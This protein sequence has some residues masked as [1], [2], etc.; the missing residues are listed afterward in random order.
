MSVLT[1]PLPPQAALTSI[2]VWRMSVDTYHAMIDVARLTS[3]DPVE[4]VEGVLV[5][6]M[7]KKAAH[8]I[9]NDRLDESIRPLLPA[10][11][12]RQ[13]QEPITLSD[14]EPEPDLTI[15][16]GRSSDYPDGHPGPPDVAL[17]VEVSDTTLRLDRDAKFRA[18]ARA[19]I[20]V[21][22]IVDLVGRTIDVHSTP[23]PAA[24]EPGY[25]HTVSYV[26]GQRVPVT[27]AGQ[28]VGEV[29]VEDILP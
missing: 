5:Y 3:D 17:V 24:V 19:G 21:Y 4:L 2:P 12:S 22:W 16:R 10:G 25:R 23:E 20:A 15:Y 28:T 27:V 13:L 14:S 18:Y 29:A 6:K 8:R 7:P 1:T 26:H 9:C 11:W